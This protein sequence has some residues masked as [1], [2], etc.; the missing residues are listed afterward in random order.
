MKT[1]TDMNQIAELDYL[2]WRILQLTR[3]QQ[4][5]LIQSIEDLLAQIGAE[6]DEPEPEE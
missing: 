5:A 2:I 3:E 4:D 1:T 6:T